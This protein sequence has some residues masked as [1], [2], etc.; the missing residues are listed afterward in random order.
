MRRGL[1]LVSGFWFLVSASF[2]ISVRFGAWRVIYTDL[3]CVCCQ[4]FIY[5]LKSSF[6]LRV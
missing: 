4:G 1:E 5:I 3:D 6:I 2:D